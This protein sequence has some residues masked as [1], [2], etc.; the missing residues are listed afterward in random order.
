MIAP[1]LLALSAAAA[2]PTVEAPP[3]LP[4][5]EQAI[6]AGRLEQAQLMVGRVIAAGESGTRV[7]VILADLAFATGKN[8]E[9]VV[10]YQKL[11]I[12]APDDSS[13]AE[14]AG[15]AALK[16]GNVALASALL[17]Q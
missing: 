3:A 4:D 2:A 14:H 7:D 17:E 5:I 9:A 12:V 13:L 11:L 15:I 16:L 10:L 8:E 1:V 6:R